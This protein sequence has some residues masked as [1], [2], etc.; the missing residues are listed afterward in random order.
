[1]VILNNVPNPTSI[2]L[3][4]EKDGK[5]YRH[6]LYGAEISVSNN[7]YGYDS[8]YIIEGTAT[9]MTLEVE[10]EPTISYRALIS[11]ESPTVSN[12]EKAR[13]AVGAPENATFI[14]TT[15]QVTDILASSGPVDVEFSWKK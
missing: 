11:I 3:E 14:I 7:E 9:S 1:M 6:V 10:Q 8:H 4:S 5:T 2:T 15:N 12:L 13:V